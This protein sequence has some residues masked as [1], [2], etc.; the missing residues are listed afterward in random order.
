MLS[1]H[2]DVAMTNIIFFHQVVPLPADQ[3]TPE[4]VM[5]MHQTSRDGLEDMSHLADLHEGAILYN[6]KLRFD[7]GDIYTYIG[8][9]LSAVNPYKS[10]EGLYDDSVLDQ[11]KEKTLGENPPHIFAI[12]NEVYYAMWKT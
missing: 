3:H 4:H 9:I 1:S 10:L 7:K 2:A 12:A 6:V 5:V 11:Y 8:S